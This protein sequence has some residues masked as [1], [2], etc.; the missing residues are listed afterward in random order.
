MLILLVLLNLPAE[1]HGIYLET[2]SVFTV[3][4][5]VW[6]APKAGA[7]QKD[8]SAAICQLADECYHKHLIAGYLPA[9]PIHCFPCLQ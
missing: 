2:S 5:F 9:Q 1:E 6:Q 4:L 3:I 8:S 7:T